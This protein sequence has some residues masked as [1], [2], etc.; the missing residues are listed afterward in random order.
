MKAVFLDFA[1]MGD[2]LRLDT[3][4]ALVDELQVF[5]ETADSELAHRIADADIVFTNK[6]NLSAELLRD[7]RK[8]RFIGL[9]AT[10]SDNVDLDCARQHGIAVCNIRAY[11]TT[12]V[13]EHVFGVLLMLGHSLPAYRRSVAG[14]AW[15]ESDMPFLL[16]HPIS[17]LRGKTIGIVGFGN[18]GQGVAGAARAFGMQV[19]VA[20]RRSAV[21]VPKDRVAFEKL[22]ARA[23]VIS[24]HCPLNDE[25][26]RM[27]GADEFGQMKESAVLINTA[28]GGLVDSA[29]LATAL[30]NRDI[31]A[32]AVDVLPVE[33][34]VDGDPLL[35]YT[36]ANL[37]VTPHIAWASDAA[38]QNA[39]DEL[40]A[41]TLAFIA[42]KTRNRVT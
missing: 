24:L 30:A 8:L 35:D 7:A 17:E 23:D 32:A 3:L 9:T 26:R 36:G 22:L 41:N 28:R 19:L 15:Q 42:G 16:D 14:G 39:I 12:S 4:R 1:T 11:C 33:P 21:T 5:D 20:A 29:A 37:I 6:M 34:P 18:L 38:R 40:T 31:A 10:G 27:F 25:T 13:V 2:G